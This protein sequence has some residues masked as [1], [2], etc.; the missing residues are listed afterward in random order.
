MNVDDE[1]IELQTRMAFQ[2]DTI[3]Q[4]NQVVSNQ[5]AQIRLIQEQLR[6][7]LERFK[8]LQHQP[9]GPGAEISD[10]RPPHY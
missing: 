8:E 1:I 6:L 7:L 4:L 5:D 9:S 2:E 3:A 10:E